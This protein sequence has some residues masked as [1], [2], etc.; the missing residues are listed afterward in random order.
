[1]LRFFA[2]LDH[3]YISEH[4]ITN[5]LTNIVDIAIRDYFLMPEHFTKAGD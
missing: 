5:G 4:C 3:L 1:M 2:Q